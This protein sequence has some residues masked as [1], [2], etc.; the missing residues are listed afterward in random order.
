MSTKTLFSRI[1]LD[2]ADD[3]SIDKSSANATL[4]R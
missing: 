3:L 4:L 2:N 1:H